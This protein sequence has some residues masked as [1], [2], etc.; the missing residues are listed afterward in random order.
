MVCNLSASFGNS[1]KVNDGVSVEDYSLHYKTVDD[2][3][4]VIHRYCSG[5]YMAKLD[6]KH[7]FIISPVRLE[8]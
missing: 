8:D 4:K 2:A 6:L 3:I 1:I 5:C 7:A